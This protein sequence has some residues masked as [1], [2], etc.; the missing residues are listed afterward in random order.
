MSTDQSEPEPGN[1][2]QDVEP[3]TVEE[4]LTMLSYH[5]LPSCDFRFAPLSTVLTWCGA[6][7]MPVQVADPRLL[8]RIDTMLVTL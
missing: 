2:K 7:G 4:M 3:A 8:D 5:T 6:M 1:P